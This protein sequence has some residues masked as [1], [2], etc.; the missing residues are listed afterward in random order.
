MGNRKCVGGLGGMSESEDDGQWKV[1]ERGTTERVHA[2]IEAVA[3]K[4]NCARSALTNNISTHTFSANSAS[5]G[6]LEALFAEARSRSSELRVQC[7]VGS[8]SRELNFS[9][10]LGEDAPAASDEPPP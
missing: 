9:V 4:Q 10:H 6:N 8:S 3:L 2:A 5:F 1:D 7:Y